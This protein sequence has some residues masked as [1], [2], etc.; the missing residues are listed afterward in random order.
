MKKVVVIA[1]AIGIVLTIFLL[2]GPF[3]TVQ[4]GEQAV[5]T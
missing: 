4:E 3:Y 5:V 1:A 2:L